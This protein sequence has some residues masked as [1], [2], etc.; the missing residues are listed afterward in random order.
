MATG[1]SVAVG[2]F[3][4]DFFQ[5]GV[6]KRTQGR[7]TR[8]VTFF[9]VWGT[10]CIAAWRLYETTVTMGGAWEWVRLVGAPMAV[11]LGAWGAFRLVNW[12]RFADFLISVEAEMNK[13]SWPS[14]G[15]LIR[16]SLVVI[17]MIF[18]LAVILFGFDILWK[19]L[20]RQ[21]LGVLS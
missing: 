9:V 2:T 4:R 6:Y 16:S 7:I 1:K 20:F 3:V 5:F 18:A 17:F 13:V 15:E 14:K 21:V 8:Q 19:F 12:T 11:L 10:A